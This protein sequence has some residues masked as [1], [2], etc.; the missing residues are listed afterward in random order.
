MPSS[1]ILAGGLGRA[2]DIYSLSMS[3][4]PVPGSYGSRD[5]P[6]LARLLTLVGGTLSQ[7]GWAFAGIGMLFAWVFVGNA[8]IASYTKFNGALER[9]TGTIERIEKTSFSE[10]GSKGRASKPVSAVHYRFTQG[11]DSYNGVSYTLSSDHT[12]GDTVNVEFPAG[13]PTTSRVVGMR[14]APF[15]AAALMVI[16]FPLIGFIMAGF[17]VL[18]GLKVQRLLRDGQ[19]TSA[20]LK[21]KRPTN[22]T[23][24]KRRVF[25]LEFEFDGRDGR[26]HTLT[27][28]SHTPEIFEDEQTEFVVY[29][30]HNPDYA[31]MRDSIP[32]GVNISESGRVIIKSW[33]FLQLIIP[34]ISI[35]GN[36]MAAHYSGV[37]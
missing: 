3:Y 14:S 8:D 21:S 28:R 31:V 10:G 24:N 36:L 18:R 4:Q 29:D 37:F 13:E 6:L 7:I 17:G 35:A 19:L 30:P 33:A 5:V 22:M 9:V 12:P 34:S 26:R 1:N 23:V 20:K 11:G 27:A 32:G 16:I 15:G 25:R 2:N